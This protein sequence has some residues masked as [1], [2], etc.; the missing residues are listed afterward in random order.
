LLGNPAIVPQNMPGGGGITPLN[1]FA[2]QVKSDGLTIAFSSSTEADPLTY[3][4]AGEI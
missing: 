1:Y 4:G 3:R 2:Q